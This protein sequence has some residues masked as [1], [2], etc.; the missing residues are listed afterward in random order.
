M[1]GYDDRI[2][3]MMM[4][5]RAYVDMVCGWGV[6]E[7]WLGVLLCCGLRSISSCMTAKFT[8]VDP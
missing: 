1:R 3:I 8:G 5:R 6:G 2:R 7:G 4:T